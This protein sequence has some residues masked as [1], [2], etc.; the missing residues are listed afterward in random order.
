MAVT[1]GCNDILIVNPEMAAVF[2]VDPKTGEVI[3]MNETD[4]RR[5]NSYGRT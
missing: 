3:W 1:F 5:T 4:R 2:G